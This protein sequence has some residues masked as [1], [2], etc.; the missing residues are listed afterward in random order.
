MLLESGNEKAVDYSEEDVADSIAE[1]T[2]E[3]GEL[4]ELVTPVARVGWDR[5]YKILT[6]AMGGLVVREVMVADWADKHMCCCDSGGAGESCRWYIAVLKGDS[7]FCSVL[8]F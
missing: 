5:C 2:E 3:L 6:K 1:Q 7:T 8:G 4:N